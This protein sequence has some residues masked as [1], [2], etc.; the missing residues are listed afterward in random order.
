MGPTVGAGT[1]TGIDRATKSGEVRFSAV[2]PIA[3]PCI[4]MTALVWPAGMVTEVLSTV[5]VEG[6]DTAKLMIWSTSSTLARDKV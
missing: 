1:K 2:L 4:L 5:A 6:S 3:N